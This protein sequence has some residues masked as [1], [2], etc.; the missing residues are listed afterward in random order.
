MRQSSREQNPQQEDNSEMPS[1]INETSMETH[2][3]YDAEVNSGHSKEI[4][5]SGNRFE[6]TLNKS[7]MQDQNI[8]KFNKAATVEVLQQVKR[9][10][11]FAQKTRSTVSTISRKSSNIFTKK[12][13]VPLRCTR[14]SEYFGDNDEAA[15]QKTTSPGNAVNLNVERLDSEADSL[16]NKD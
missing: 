15:P 2:V 4:G 13:N 7:T 6:A 12:R 5:R 16:H 11:I 10:N 9:P 8:Q 14:N 3:S 1:A